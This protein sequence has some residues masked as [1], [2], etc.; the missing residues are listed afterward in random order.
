MLRIITT[1]FGIVFILL[2]VLG[3]VPA[4]KTEADGLTYL[5]NLFVTEPWHVALHM[6]SGAFAL[7]AASSERYSRWY[8]QIFGLAYA[9]MSLAGLA[10]GDAVLGLFATNSA[11]NILYVSFAV[12]LLAAGF[13]IPTDDGPAAPSKTV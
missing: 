3:L 13:G 11:T 8:L 7:L 6:L 5:F 10:Q 1:I 2:G 12:A 9:A 4:I